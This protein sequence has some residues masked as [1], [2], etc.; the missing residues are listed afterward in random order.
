MEVESIGAFVGLDLL[1]SG[2]KVANALLEFVGHHIANFRT[3]QDVI[4]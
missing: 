4:E 1:H 3:H 2:L